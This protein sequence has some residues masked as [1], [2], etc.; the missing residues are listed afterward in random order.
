MVS[1]H[2]KECKGDIS[3]ELWC[4]HWRNVNILKKVL[5]TFTCFLY[6]NKAVA[7]RLWDLSSAGRASAL[8]AEGHRFEPCRSH[9]YFLRLPYGEI[10]QLAR[11]HGSYPWCRGFESPSRYDKK[12]NPFGFS[13]LSYRKKYEP[14]TPRSGGEG[15]RRPGG[16]ERPGDVRLA[17]TEVKRRTS[18]LRRAKR[19]VD[20]NPPLTIFYNIIDLDI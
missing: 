7:K 19:S 9:S 15:A 6:I 8:Q 13:F 17:P 18:V 5:D 20:P 3:C 16:A 4:M 14:E 11:A 1:V 12:E 10:A 2:L